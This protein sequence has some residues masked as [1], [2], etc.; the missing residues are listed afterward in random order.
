MIDLDNYNV[1][2]KW[3]SKTRKSEIEA[4]IYFDEDNNIMVLD[5]NRNVT[6]FSLSPY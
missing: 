6:S 4:G 2:M 1:I 5:R 3:L